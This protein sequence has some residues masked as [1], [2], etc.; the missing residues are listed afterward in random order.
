MS[1]YLAGGDLIDEGCEHTSEN[2]CCGQPAATMD[3]V[4]GRR[5][6]QHPPTYSRPYALAAVDRGDVQLAC[7]HLRAH[8]AFRLRGAA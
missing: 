3:G 4:H 2:G 8:V 5:C 7:A 1:R 6:A